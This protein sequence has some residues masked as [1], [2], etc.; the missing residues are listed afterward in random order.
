MAQLGGTWGK[1]D[2]GGTDAAN[3]N[4]RWSW[5]LPELKRLAKLIA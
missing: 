4:L 3:T 2:E 5:A 1:P